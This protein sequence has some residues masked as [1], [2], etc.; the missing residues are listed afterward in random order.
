VSRYQQ[1]VNWPLVHN[2]RERE[3]KLQ[4]AFIKATEADYLVDVAFSRNWRKSREAGITRGAYH[5]FRF[6]VPAAS[7]ARLFINTVKLQPGDLPPVLDVEVFGGTDKEAL[8]NEVQLWLQ[9]IEQHYQLKP[10]IYTNASFYNRWLWPRFNEY[11][12]WV[13][14]YFERRQPRVN[15]NW[16]FWQHNES[17]RVNGIKSFVDFNVFNGSRADF[18]A[19]LKR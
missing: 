1:S 5:F 11:P 2:M 3:V 4:F 6:G 7:Q 18:E 16:Q 9:L 10:I 13:A 12:L 8:Q 17:G 19:L 15:R 14:H